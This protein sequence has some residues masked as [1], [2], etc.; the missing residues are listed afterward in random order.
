MR[1]A[2]PLIERR[3]SSVTLGRLLEGESPVLAAIR[4]REL[5]VE[6]IEHGASDDQT[7]LVACAALLARSH[8]P[9]ADDVIATI[10]GTALAGHLAR[11]V[12]DLAESIERGT[13]LTREV[14]R[15]QVLDGLADLAV[16]AS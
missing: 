4:L 12:G 15:Q 1:E 8:H 14:L 9:S 10:A 16:E 11:T 2:L 13:R 5:M 3:L 7:V 6:Q